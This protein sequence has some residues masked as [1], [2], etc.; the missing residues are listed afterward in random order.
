M[1]SFSPC[2]S[3]AADRLTE[4]TAN[5][6]VEC[7]PLDRDRYGRLVSRCMAGDI[8]LA[9]ALAEEG[10]A[11]TYL[12]YSDDYAGQEAAARVAAAG[13]W[14]SETQAPWDYR[15]NRWER[16]EAASPAPG[17]PITGNISA[18]GERIYHTPWSP[19]YERTKISETDGE[20]WF[21]DEAEAV[22]A[23]WRAAQSR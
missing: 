8:D 20:R 18:K 9:A 6:T 1:P 3:T 15:A 17:C 5:T 19:W 16:A 21:C 7:E 22:E 11:W 4:L 14:Q 13:V 10:L 2:G 23:G 12:E